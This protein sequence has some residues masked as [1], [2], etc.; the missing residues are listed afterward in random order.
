[1]G[2]NLSSYGRITRKYRYETSSYALGYHSGVDIVLSN[3]AILSFTD[4]TVSKKGY[5]N[6]W[7]NY[8]VI[9]SNDGYYCWYA[10]MK[11]PCSLA[12]GQ[13]VVAGQTRIGTMGSTGNSTGPHLHFEVRTSRDNQRSNIDPVAYLKNYG[14]STAGMNTTEGKIYNYLTG[15]MGLNTAAACGIL[16]N[17]EKESD[18]GVTKKE[19]GGGGYGLV[20]WTGVRLTRLKSWCAANNK[21]YNSL[22]GQLAFLS[23]E[24]NGD[25]N[26][27][28]QRLKSV[29]NTPEGAYQAGY[30]FCYY[31]ERPANYVQRSKERGELAK[32]YFNKYINGLIETTGTT[33]GE[34]VNGFFDK[35]SAGIEY[36]QVNWKS[37]LVR[38]IFMLM[39]IFLIFAAVKKGFLT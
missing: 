14:G 11:S 6:S 8:C 9:Q 22:E 21:S 27:T 17:I 13:R 38:V 7:G 29:A 4:G 5:S 26:S 39:A 30:Y 12:I 36:L 24:L 33:G 31:F 23:Y 16:A 28:L 19:V 10:H 20:Q 34:S 25:Y 1:M 32:V 15:T 2:V 37:V 3:P 35:L 18:F